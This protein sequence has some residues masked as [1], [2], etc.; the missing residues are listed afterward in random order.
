[1]TT[2]LYVRFPMAVGHEMHLELG[3]TRAIILALL[4]TLCIAL[5]A[6]LATRQGSPGPTTF[7]KATVPSPLARPEFASQRGAPLSVARDTRPEVEALAASLA[8]RYRVSIEATRGVIAAAYR[9][10]QRIGLDPLLIVAVIAVES[11]FNPIA[12][13]EMGA[14]GL[15]QVIPRFH[16]DHLEAAGVDSVLDPHSNIRVGARVLKDYIRSGG[17]EV[18]GLQRYNGS[19]TDSTNAYATKVLGEKGR[20]QQSI[21]QARDRLRA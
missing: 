14:Q 13:S 16:K 20:L 5:V 19:S 4:V 6:T 9:E 21:R 8:K 3:R 7:A 17:N 1:M 2:S 10:G 18:A 15:M 12:E 11:R